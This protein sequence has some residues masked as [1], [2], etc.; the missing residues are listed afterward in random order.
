V[1]RHRLAVGRIDEAVRRTLADG[2]VVVL[3]QLAADVA[4]GGVLGAAG[5]NLMNQ[6]WA[7]VLPTSIKMCFYGSW[8]RRI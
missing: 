3:P 7:N 1:D 4:A 8:I 6:F 2:E 5:N